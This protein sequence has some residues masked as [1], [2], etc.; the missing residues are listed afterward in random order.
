M[1]TGVAPFGNPGN[2]WGAVNRLAQSVP[3]HAVICD[4]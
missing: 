4:R 1:S 2:K 3:P